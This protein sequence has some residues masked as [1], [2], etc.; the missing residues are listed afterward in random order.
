[1]FWP[2]TAIFTRFAFAAC[3][4]FVVLLYHH[5]MDVLF[6]IIA[7]GAMIS[8]VLSTLSFLMFPSRVHRGVEAQRYENVR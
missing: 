3:G 1:M 8:G 2:I 4:S 5:N 6:S 7:I